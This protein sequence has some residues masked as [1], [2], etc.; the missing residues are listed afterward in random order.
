MRSRCL[1]YAIRPNKLGPQG[2]PSLGYGFRFGYW[3]CLQGPYLQ[4]AIHQWRIEVWF[5]L[6]SYRGSAP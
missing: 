1:R 6:P 4:L 2:T 3:P 5:G